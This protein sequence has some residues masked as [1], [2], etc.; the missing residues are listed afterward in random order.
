MYTYDDHG[1]EK[2]LPEGVRITDGPRKQWIEKAWPHTTTFLY[3]KPVGGTPFYGTLTEVAVKL[4]MRPPRL[5]RIVRE[6]R[7]QD[8]FVVFRIPKTLFIARTGRKS[9]FIWEY[10]WEY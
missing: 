8:D 10:F 5:S 7:E 6:R 9:F 3:C 4:G 2:T 1:I